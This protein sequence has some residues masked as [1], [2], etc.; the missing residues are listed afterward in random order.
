MQAENINENGLEYFNA[1]FTMSEFRESIRS[2]KLTKTS[3]PDGPLAEMIK[4]TVN[5]IVQ[6]V[7]S[8]YNRILAL[9]WL[10]KNW[11]ES[12]LCPVFKAGFLLDPNN[13][14]GVINRRS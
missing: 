2:L 10:P 14:R 5:E 7:L 4:N 11:S 1:P 12:I 8:L 3:G 13:Y 6:I 9:G